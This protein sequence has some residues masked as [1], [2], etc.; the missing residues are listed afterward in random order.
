M[1]M[2]K[3]GGHFRT[4][5]EDTVDLVRRLA[6]H[7]DDKTIAVI[8]AQQRRRTGTG[9]PFTKSRVAVAARLP[10]HPRLPAAAGNCHTRRR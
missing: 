1:P 9:L 2:T 3:T 4:T 8:L 7:Y 6:A 10:R 5:D